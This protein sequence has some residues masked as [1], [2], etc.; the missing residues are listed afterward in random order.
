MRDKNE[1]V[2]CSWNEDTKAPT[3]DLPNAQGDTYVAS[4]TDAGGDIG[5]RR[6]RASDMGR[7]HHVASPVRMSNL[8]H[9][10]TMDMYLPS[11]LSLGPDNGESRGIWP[12]SLSQR[13]RRLADCGLTAS[14]CA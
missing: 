1:S 2:E 13:G 8:T 11:L 7:A 4:G 12:F 3:H 9:Q 6:A 5:F 14:N 10:G